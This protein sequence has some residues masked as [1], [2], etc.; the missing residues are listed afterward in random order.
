MSSARAARWASAPAACT[1]DSSVSERHQA[2]SA[3]RRCRTARARSPSVEQL[4]HQPR[5]AG[6]ERDADR[7]LPAPDGAARDSSRPATLA[8][9]IASTRPTATRARRRRMPIAQWPN[10][11]Q[12]AERRELRLTVAELRS[13]ARRGRALTGGR[14][15]G[16]PL[17]RS[18]GRRAAGRRARPRRR[19]RFVE[20]GIS[21][22]AEGQVDFRREAVARDAPQPRAAARPAP[23]RRGR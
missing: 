7:N 16:S 14:Q 4:L 8:Q 6:A 1:R 21:F 23:C 9:A 17:R 19:A 10:C 20:S 12:A 2:A 5:A 18:S 13:I 15:R 3:R 11:P 22:A